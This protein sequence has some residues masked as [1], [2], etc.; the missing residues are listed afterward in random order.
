MFIE[1]A[2]ETLTVETATSVSEGLELFERGDYDCIVSGYEMAEQDGIDFL[3]AIREEYPEFPFV[4]FTGAG[5]ESVASEAMSKGVSE[6]VQKRSNSDQYA[7]LANRVRNLVEKSR[8]RSK[9]RRQ[10][11]RQER[12]EQYHR[13][14]L[15]ITSDPAVSTDRKIQQMLELLGEFFEEGNSYLV[16]INEAIDRYRIV[17]A[18]GPVEVVRDSKLSEAYCRRTIESDE[19]FEVYNAEELGWLGDPAYDRWGLGC[20]LGKK[21][22]V[23]GE[24]YGTVCFGDEE[25]RTEPFTADER[26]FFDLVCG[27]IHQLLERKRRRGQFEALFEHSIDGTFLVDVTPDRTFEFRQVSGIFE[28]L[29]ERSPQDFVGTS[30]REAFG[31]GSDADAGEALESRFRDCADRRE[32]VEFERELPLPEP[33]ARWRTKVA[34]VVE[35]DDV[36][37]LV[38]TARRLSDER[39]SEPS[40]RQ[41]S[42]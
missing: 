42:R 8:S 6:Y 34:P 26:A 25:P 5:S 20:Y 13:A 17:C 18:S 14:L 27:S 23:E 24:L 37:Q 3:A 2:D 35:A 9:L 40:E 32:P 41:R 19:I 7:L 39:T 1:R 30:P 11:Q 15:E 33:G 28:E 29:A 16:N 38:G 36:I 22:L 4:L 31:G 12:G 21:L 10:A